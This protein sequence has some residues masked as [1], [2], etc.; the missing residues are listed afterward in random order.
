[1][2]RTPTFAPFT[3][4]LPRNQLAKTLMPLL[5][6]GMLMVGCTVTD[7]EEISNQLPTTSL[8][9]ATP[10]PTLLL[11]DYP[12]GSLAI[13]IHNQTGRDLDSVTTIYGDTTHDFGAIAANAT[14]DFAHI[15]FAYQMFEGRI[16]VDG[17]T[18]VIDGS[19]MVAMSGEP[20]IVGGAYTFTISNV[21]SE[22]RGGE[23]RV[24]EDIVR[25]WL[26]PLL[27]KLK[28]GGA[29]AAYTPSAQ[30]PNMFSL[31]YD[32]PVAAR[33]LLQLGQERI[34]VY[35]FRDVGSAENALT[36]LQLDSATIIG[37]DGTTYEPSFWSGEIPVWWHVGN[38]LL[39]ANGRDGKTHEQITTALGIDPLGGMVA[40]FVP[41]P[42]PE[43]PLINSDI[44]MARRNYDPDASETALLTGELVIVENCLYVV[45][46]G[47]SERYLPIWPRLY[48]LDES[49][50]IPAVLDESGEVVFRIGER[51]YLGGSGG[52]GDNIA[53]R[54][55]TPVPDRCDSSLVWHVGSILPPEYRDEAVATSDHFGVYD[56]VSRQ[57]FGLEGTVNIRGRTFRDGTSGY[58]PSEVAAL[59]TFTEETISDFHRVNVGLK[60]IAAA[61][62]GHS[63]YN[64]VYSGEALADES[65]R[66][67]DVGFNE[68]RSQAL[69]VVCHDGAGQDFC[70]EQF[71][72]VLEKVDGQW[73]IAEQVEIAR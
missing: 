39:L 32:E 51:A 48:T 41:T 11:A 3:N 57:L 47:S 71:Y 50:V 56:A 28:D 60:E 31:A 19:E 27:D 13:R 36:R 73:Q 16:E 2:K 10:Q 42:T 5:V 4:W 58:L 67:S 54:L 9:T 17:E 49:S 46:D 22:I 18:Y 15:P 26:Q 55:V 35:V 72:V 12:I 20:P 45:G 25:G 43:T 38:V 59:S 21:N 62:E 7:S 6:A 61:F 68:A 23:M 52:R 33:E 8:I 44:Y 40:E 66:F 30:R 64:I 1:M 24:E 53:N 70:S 65:L 34:V 29:F 69:V 37:D 14:T 63:D